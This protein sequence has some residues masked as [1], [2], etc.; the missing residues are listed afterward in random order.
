MTE[1]S[2]SATKYFFCEIGELI[3][4]HFAECKFVFSC[5]Q[6][7]S[8]HEVA[9]KIVLE[10][11]NGAFQEDESSNEYFACNGEVVMTIDR[12]EQISEADFEVLQKYLMDRTPATKFL[13]DFEAERKQ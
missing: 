4:D 7:K 3:G 5:P 12:C 10:S 2:K 8:S 11:R 6:E 13:S 1:S 9:E